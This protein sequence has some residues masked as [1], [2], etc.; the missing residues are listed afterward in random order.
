MGKRSE[1]RKSAV[2]TRLILPTNERQIRRNARRVNASNVPRRQ[3][4]R[5]TAGAAALPAVS[6]DATAQSYPV[7]P[8]TMI[9][10]LAA[11]GAVMQLDEF[12]LTE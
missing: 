6:H 11:G 5:L 7:R 3:F 4:L 1:N 2:E 10:P 12:L 8:I 9:V